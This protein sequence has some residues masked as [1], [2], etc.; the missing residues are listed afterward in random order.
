VRGNFVYFL[1][2]WT[3]INANEEEERIYP[4]KDTNEREGKGIEFGFVSSCPFVSF[5]SFV[6][7][8]I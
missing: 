3:Q 2:R 5:V 8:I 4:R 7:K 1:S 6:D